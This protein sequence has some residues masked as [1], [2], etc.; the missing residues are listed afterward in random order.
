MLA[1]GPTA[2]VCGASLLSKHIAVQPHNRALF[3]LVG[4]GA[5]KCAGKLR[6]RVKIKL[7][8]GR[9]KLKTIGTAVFSIAAGKRVS[10]IVKLNAAG[11]AV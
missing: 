7:G 10:V 8:G 6:L 1:F 2:S 5:G 3:K 4:T 11:R 9:F